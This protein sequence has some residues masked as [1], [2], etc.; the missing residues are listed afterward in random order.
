MFPGKLRYDET[1]I[2]RSGTAIL[3]S[4]YDYREDRRPDGRG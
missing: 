1:D 4:G 2:V 3:R